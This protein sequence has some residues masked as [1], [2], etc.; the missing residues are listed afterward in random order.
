MTSS[1]G[2]NEAISEHGAFVDPKYRLMTFKDWIYDSDPAALCTSKKLAEA[3]FISAV[4]PDDPYAASCAFCL[5]TLEWE[6]HDEPEQEHKSH[7]PKCLFVTMMLGDAPKELTVEDSIR[8]IFYRYGN[9]NCAVQI[10]VTS[11]RN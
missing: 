10:S 4:T 1:S 5:K 2:E 6:A 11:S 7:C 8:L 9:V 3:G